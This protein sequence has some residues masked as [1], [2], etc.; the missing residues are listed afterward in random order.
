MIEYR[1]QATE[2]TVEALRRLRGEWAGYALED[3]QVVV[4]LADGDTITITVDTVDVE[5]LFDAYRVNAVRAKLGHAP[6]PDIESA[7]AFANGDNDIVLFSG[8]SWSEPA[9][10]LVTGKFGDNASLNFSGHLGQLTETAEI[11]CITTDAFVV[12]TNTGE[13][14]LFRTGLRPESVE[15]VTDQGVVRRFLIERGYAN[16]E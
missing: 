5:G 13:G 8:V 11:I 15:V 14:L 12:A 7:A 2:E 16:D 9:S 6:P 3:M 4:Y 1:F 10:S